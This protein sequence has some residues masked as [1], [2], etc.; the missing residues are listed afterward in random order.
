[1]IVNVKSKYKSV[2]DILAVAIAKKWSLRRF[3]AERDKHNFAVRSACGRYGSG[4]P[5][6]I[7]P[8]LRAAQSKR[9]RERWAAW[10]KSAE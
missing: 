5:K 7:T 9:A 6:T 3:A 1:M 4:R 2:N 10:R 8:Q